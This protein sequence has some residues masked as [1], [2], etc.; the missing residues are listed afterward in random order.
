MQFPFDFSNL[1]QKPYFYDNECLDYE[2][3][4]KN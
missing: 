3:Y 2:K 1:S 4:E